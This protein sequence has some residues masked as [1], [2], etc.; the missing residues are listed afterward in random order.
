MRIRVLFFATL[1]E[2]TG[3]REDELDLPEGARVADL[4]DAVAKRHP[5]AAR[6][7]PTAL[8]AVNREFAF[9]QEEL[10]E[11]DEVALFPP[12]SG[13]QGTQMTL[14]RLTR[15]TFDMNA[16][17]AELVTPTAGAACMFTGIVRRRTQRGVR[18]E[19]EYLEY[20]AYVEMAKGKLAQIAGEIRERWPTV[21]GIAL[22]QRLG[23]IDPGVPSVLVACTAPHRDSGV[24]DAAR[25][26][27]DRLKQIV[28]IWKKEIGPT[29]EV[30]VE[31][32]YAP[33]EGDKR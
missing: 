16:I 8:A 31:G 12:V 27:I 30:W 17:L 13:G 14:I 25:Y 21:E 4:R 24:F 29:G 3:L 26:G 10:H 22:V 23:H 19:T 18:R 2:R 15:D 7:L 1:R 20:E 28:P 11:G 5:D 9:P 33:T 6:A 32:D